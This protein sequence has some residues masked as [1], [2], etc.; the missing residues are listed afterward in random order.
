MRTILGAGLS[1]LICGAMNGQATIYERSSPGTVG[2]RAVLRFRDEKI[3]RAL[4]IPFRRVTVR[5]GV[6][7]GGKEVPPS[8][9]L[10]NWYSM[11]VRGVIGDAS[12]WKLDPSER[13][14]APYN[15]HSILAGICHGRIRWNHEVDLNDLRAMA[16]E[17]P[18]I[19]T[20]PLPVV[21]DILGEQV[22]EALKFRYWPIEVNRFLIPDCDVFQTI[23]FPDLEMPVY[24]A[25]L[26]GNLLTIESTGPIDM[27]QTEEVTRAF[28]LRLE[29]LVPRTQKHK[30]S[31]GKIAPVPDGPRKA[32][33][34]HLTQNWNIYSLGRFATWRNILLDDV[35]EDIAAIRRMM[36]Q[37]RYDYQIE[38]TK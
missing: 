36:S 12:I 33:L 3:G 10:A 4:G 17:G 5:K 31:F 28:G 34:L 25:T 20:L 24:R 8:P 13:Y 21:T 18:V 29:W 1:G 23:Y 38:R 30:Q 11:K 27:D 22:D 9:R 14:I 37:S 15:L 16:E 35:F 32:L 2:H 7:S 6:W 26:T 19:S